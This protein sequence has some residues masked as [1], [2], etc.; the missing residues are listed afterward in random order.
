MLHGFYAA[1][2]DRGLRYGVRDGGPCSKLPHRAIEP[3]RRRGK[4]DS[5]H[6]NDDD[7]DDDDDDDNDED[8]ACTRVSATL[9]YNH[10][11]FSAILGDAA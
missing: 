7:D 9:K 6:C 4:S 11:G 2:L 10:R 3:I 8:G 1:A 5:Y